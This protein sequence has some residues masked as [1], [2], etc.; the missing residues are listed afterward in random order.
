MT[1]KGIGVAVAIGMVL[2]ACA[3]VEL[4]PAG[5]KTR[6]LSAEEVTN[7]KR[8]GTTTASVKAE[9]AGIERAPERVQEELE[10]LARNSA[11]AD[12]KGDTVVPIGKPKDGKQ[13]FEVY[14]CVQ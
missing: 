4:S 3:W 7:C 5:E 10:S 8:L 12:L 1:I 9:V 6:V 2:Q 13:V 14:R 11:A